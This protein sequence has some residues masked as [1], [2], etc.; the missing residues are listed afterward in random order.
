MPGAVFNLLDHPRTQAAPRILQILPRLDADGP[1]RNA[2][3]IARAAIAEG[4]VAVAASRSGA[5]V[6][7]FRQSGGIHMA[8]PFDSISPVAR[9]RILF[10]LRGAVT[11]HGI[12]VIHAYG[13]RGARLAR[14]L[15][16]STGVP[17]VVS[18][19]ASENHAP[20]QWL[21]ADMAAARAVVAASDFVAAL[22][23]KALPAGTR[24]EIIPRGVDLLRFDPAVIRAEKLVRQMQDWRADELSAVILMPG[25]LAPG[26]GHDILLEAMSRMANKQ[27]TCLIL[28]REDENP[29]Y[30]AALLHL[31]DTLRLAGR[32]RF[33]SHAPDMPVAYMIADVVAVPSRS[34]EA[35]NSICAEAL[36]MG[37]PVVA[38]GT[39]GTPDIVI[40]GETGWLV[41]PVDPDALAAALDEALALDE[42]ARIRLAK[43]SRA[44]IEHHYSLGAARQR[45]MTLYR[46]LGPPGRS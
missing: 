13:R 36:A 4:G 39:G 26:K 15:S 42:T 31:I 41:P 8:L 29:R 9:L 18:P 37:R 25:R 28:A 27:A 21:T 11:R 16:A 14:R 7:E 32:V 22:V 23:P 6:G 24:V 33:V 17:F 1:S 34:P 12:T 40:D 2:I 19:T 30:H 46:G 35:F 5:L 38:S 44:H 10:R 45:I 43:A 20:D 3:D